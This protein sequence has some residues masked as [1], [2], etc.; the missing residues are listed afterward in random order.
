MRNLKR[1]LN[2][3]SFPS[4]LRKFNN[5][6][7]LGALEHYAYI[8]W[9]NPFLTFYVN[10]RSFSWKQAWRFPIWIYGRP[11]LFSLNGS[12]KIIGDVKSG[13][14]RFNFINPGSPS[15]AGVQSEL[16][17]HGTI[18]FRGTAY[19]RTGCH[20]N[21]N[22]NA[23]LE[24]GNHV[25]IGNNI[26]IGCLKKIQI[27]DNTRIS[28]MSQILDSNYHFTINANKKEVFPTTTPIFVGRNC[29][30]ANTTTISKGAVIP[31]YTIVCSNSLVNKDF[32]SLDKGSIIGGTPA[33]PLTSGHYLINNLE[34]E[35]IIASHF[36][37][38]PDE[39]FKLSKDMDLTNLTEFE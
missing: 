11:K 4:L 16:I 17:N 27:G 30:I 3:N 26:N 24:I 9:F 33:K 7:G 38:H 37:S 25:I 14:I 35:K 21:V 28:H 19:I 39:K 31:D 29:W 1:L 5:K 8:N 6:Y 10:L 2:D 13:M 34:M 20:I 12:M 22:F 36:K 18:I 15:N 32:S 23:I